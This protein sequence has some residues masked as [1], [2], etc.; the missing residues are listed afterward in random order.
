MFR[1]PCPSRLTYPSKPPFVLCHKKRGAIIFWIFCL[2][3]LLYQFWKILLK[4]LLFLHICFWMP[5]TRHHLSPLMPFQYAVDRRLS[6]FVSHHL[7]RSE[8][9]TSELQ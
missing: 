2:L 4:I 8:E 7:F 1:C 9:H 3:Q 5:G 6:H